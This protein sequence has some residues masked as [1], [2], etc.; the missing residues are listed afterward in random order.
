MEQTLITQWNETKSLRA[1][2][3]AVEPCGAL[4]SVAAVAVRAASDWGQQPDH[5]PL[6]AAVEGLQLRSVGAAAIAATELERCVSLYFTDRL[7]H[8]LIEWHQL[9]NSFEHLHVVGAQRIHDPR[10]TRRLSPLCLGN[11]LRGKVAVRQTQLIT[12]TLYT[13]KQELATE[14]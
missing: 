11:G 4:K 8:I 7:R 14:A 1:D 12:V 6:M 5:Q 10:P 3:L 9:Q 13:H 2:L